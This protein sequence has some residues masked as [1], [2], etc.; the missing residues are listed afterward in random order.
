MLTCNILVILLFD[1]TF[2]VTNGVRQVEI[3]SSYLS[4]VHVYALSE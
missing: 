4:N 3:L 2:K 1:Y